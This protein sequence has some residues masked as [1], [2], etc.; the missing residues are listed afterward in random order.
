VIG[1]RGVVNAGAGWGHAV[2]VAAMYYQYDAAKMLPDHGAD[3]NAGNADGCR[4]S[5]SRL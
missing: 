2:L 4:R 3:I 1:A 5:T